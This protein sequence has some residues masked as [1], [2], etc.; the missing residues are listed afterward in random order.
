[1]YLKLIVFAP[2]WWA[3]SDYMK[4]PYSVDKIFFMLLLL[5]FVSADFLTADDWISWGGLFFGAVLLCFCY[6]LK[7]IQGNEILKNGRPP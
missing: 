5:I 4:L 3:L 6:R 2:I 7:N 1:M